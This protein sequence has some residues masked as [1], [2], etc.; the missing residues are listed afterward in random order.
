M[1]T[2][3][4][5][6]LRTWTDAGWLRELDLAFADFIAPAGAGQDPLVHLAAALL[7]HQVGRS[8]VRLDLAATL[9]APDFVLSLP[10]EGEEGSTLPSQCLASEATWGSAALSTAVPSGSTTSIWVRM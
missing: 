10:P 5:Q 7:S 2:A 9:A 3:M 4:S 1:T 8:Q 6:A